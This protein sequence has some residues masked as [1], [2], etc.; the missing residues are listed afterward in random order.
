MLENPEDYIDIDHE[1]LTR[2]INAGPEVQTA[3]ADI[4][5]AYLLLMMRTA[6]TRGGKEFKEETV[7]E[8][9][10]F[11]KK[12]KS[13]IQKDPGDELSNDEILCIMYKVLFEIATI[14]HYE[15]IELNA[16]F[17]FDGETDQ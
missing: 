3:C 15:S 10:V 5:N 6:L 7:K 16:L 2:F 11:R 9:R 14:K 12:F 8:A 17:G 4:V 13:L 1:L